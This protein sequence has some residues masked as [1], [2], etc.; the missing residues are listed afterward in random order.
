MTH[1]AMKSVIGKLDIK[2]SSKK[3]EEKH[4]DF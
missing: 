4:S 2:K 1:M 3:K